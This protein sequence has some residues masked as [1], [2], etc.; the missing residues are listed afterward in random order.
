MTVPA[1]PQS[2]ETPPLEL[3]GGDE[4]VGAELAVAL[5][6]LDDRAERAQRLDHERGVARVQ[7]RAQQRRARRRGR[8]ARARGS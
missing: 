6:L 8:R 7:R 2:I 1:R 4:Q 3:A 5:D